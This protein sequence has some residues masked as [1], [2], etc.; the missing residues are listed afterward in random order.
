[1]TV[2]TRSSFYYVILELLIGTTVVLVLVTFRTQKAY[3]LSVEYWA[4]ETKLKNVYERNCCWWRTLVLSILLRQ[5]NK[6][7]F[8]FQLLWKI[9][10]SRCRKDEVLFIDY[11]RM[12]FQGLQKCS[13]L[14]WES[15]H[16]GS[17]LQKLWPWHPTAC[18]WLLSP[19]W[20]CH[21]QQYQLKQPA[22]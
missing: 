4:F 16:K 14:L 5:R 2:R 12:C 6:Q 17:L 1:M 19:S 15:L 11:A 22:T 10:K 9:L 13:L 7:V 20:L 8:N 18:W 21:W 3:I